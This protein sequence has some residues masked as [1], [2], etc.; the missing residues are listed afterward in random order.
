L[1]LHD[2]QLPG[3]ARSEPLSGFLNRRVL[4]DCFDGAATFCRRMRRQIYTHDDLVASRGS[5]RF[6]IGLITPLAR[7]G[8]LR[9][10][11]AL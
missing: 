4:V 3:I 2:D 7:F 8:R 11:N 9:A 6:V 10:H 1:P 5:V